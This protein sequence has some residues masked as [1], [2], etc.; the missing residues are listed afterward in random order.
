MLGGAYG[1]WTEACD[2]ISHVLALRE[3][4]YPYH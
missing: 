3:L 1:V 2:T 4:G